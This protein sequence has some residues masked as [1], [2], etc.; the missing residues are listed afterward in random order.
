[1]C[2][3]C[4]VRPSKIHYTEIVNDN[5]VTMDL[6]VEC[7]EARGIDV[8]RAGSYGLGD[9]VAGLID[10]SARTETEHIGKV[11]CPN[12]G[13]DYSNFKKSGRLG[14]PECYEAFEAQLMP[15]LRQIHGSTQHQGNTPQALGQKALI[16][17]ELADLK[18]ALARAVDEEEYEKAARI[19]DRIRALEAGAEKK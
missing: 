13:F 14:C 11:R 8:Q 17:K 16:R 2:K 7:A 3:E 4:G 10:N 19:R 6:C 18:E 12:C 5:M 9:L 1:M 15:L